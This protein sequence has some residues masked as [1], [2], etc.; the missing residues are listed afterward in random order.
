MKTFKEL[1]E[2]I[3]LN[4]IEALTHKKK[5][6]AAQ[7]KFDA[8][9]A[10][11]YKARDAHNDLSQK[12]KI[13]YIKAMKAK[14]HPRDGLLRDPPSDAHKNADYVKHRAHSTY[15]K[16][17]HDASKGDMKA[18]HT[19]ADGAAG[20]FQHIPKKLDDHGVKLH[21]NMVDA[22]HKLQAAKKA[23]PLHKAKSA[24]HKF[25]KK[26]GMKEDRRLDELSPELLTRYT[27]KAIPRQF[28]KHQAARDRGHDYMTGKGGDDVAKRQQRDAD[29]RKKGID[30]V[31][32]R[33]N[34]ADKGHFK[35][36]KASRPQG[37]LRPGKGSPYHVDPAKLKGFGS[38]YLDQ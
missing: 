14:G 19:L 23:S 36:G 12:H 10:A 9:R 2:S 32:K 3:L 22:H 8:A 35:T 11:H 33:G 6:A 20:H 31:Q 30:S 17:H 38:K 16:L 28:K 13:A 27:K 37:G 24:I 7:A 5:I 1:R 34:P 18:S 26:V 21:N 25:A 29:K 4:E 15:F